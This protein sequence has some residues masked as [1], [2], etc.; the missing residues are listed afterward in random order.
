MLTLTPLA[1]AHAEALFPIWSDWQVTRFTY[2]RDIAT[3]EDCRARI[4][5]ILEHGEGVGPFVLQEGGQVVGLAG[6]ITDALPGEYSAYYHLARP[7][8]GRGL[9]G[10]AMALLLRHLFLDRQASVVR[11]KVVS[12]NVASWRLLERA[13]LHRTGAQPDGFANRDGVYDLFSYAI[14][15]DAYLAGLSGE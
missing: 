9:G 15:R 3:L 8:W 4:D 1:P 6:A 10:Q 13:G 12:D 14:A 11:A 2:V 5:W 7:H